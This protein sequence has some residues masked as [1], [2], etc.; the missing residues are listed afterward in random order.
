[1]KLSLQVLNAGKATGQ[2]IPINVA[3]FLI[4]RDPKCSLRPASAMISKQHCALIIKDGKVYLKD[5]NSTNGTFLNDQPVK[6]AV[7]LKHD[8]ILKVGPL[9]FKVLIEGMPSVTKPTPPPPAKVPVIA[10]N[11]DDPAAAL[12]LALDEGDSPNEALVSTTEDADAVPGGSTIM[13]MPVVP[14]AT[15]EAAAP[16]PE[17]EKK[18]D[19]VEAKKADDKKSASGAAQQAAQ[20]ILERYKKGRRG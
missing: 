17:E 5:F 1:M 3:N 12:L 20:A 18:A 15:A 2:A 7:V 11:E 13:E 14:P 9:T 10:A 19:K 16:E 4:G 8:D 6:G